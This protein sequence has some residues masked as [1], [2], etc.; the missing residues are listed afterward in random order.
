[1]TLWDVSPQKAREAS[2]GFIIALVLV[3]FL[4]LVSL[5]DSCKGES[6]DN[7]MGGE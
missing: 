3:T 7:D 1:M 5:C 2:G 6:D 4:L